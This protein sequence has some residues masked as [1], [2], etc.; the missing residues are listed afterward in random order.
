M[1]IN[2]T[3]PIIYPI[4]VPTSSTLLSFNFYLVKNQDK[5]FLVD[6][7]LDSEK[8]WLYFNHVLKEN[9]FKLNDINGIILTHSHQDHTGIVN[10]VLSLHEIPVY[11]HQSSLDRL[12]RNETFLNKR[13]DFFRS[14]YSEMGCK[15]MGE[16][17]VKLLQKKA[18]QNQYQAIK[19]KILPLK[20]GDRIYGFKVIETPGHWPDHIAL[21]NPESG[22]LLGGDHL[23]QHIS[24]N[25]LIEPD[26]LGKKISTLQQYERSLKKCKDYALTV[27]YPGHGEI[28]EDPKELIKKRLN[29]IESKSEKIRKIIS[30]K[31]PCTA[32]QVAQ[33]YYEHKY[34]SEFSLVMSEIIGHLYRLEGLNKISKKQKNSEWHYYSC[35]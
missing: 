20:E 27:T 10:R 11:A 34:D 18:K 15:E 7:G 23:I 29:G 5:L 24:S 19:A 16:K 33:T 8:C 31:Q 12:A 3:A 28:V 9:G 17:Q 30:N 22:I 32:A 14:L 21:L 35:G 26:E 2:S 25:A 4:I 1:N 6:A 13:I